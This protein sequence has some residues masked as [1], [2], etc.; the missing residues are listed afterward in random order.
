MALTGT[1]AQRMAARDEIREI[2]ASLEQ[3]LERARKQDSMP[4]RLQAL[5]SAL[6]VLLHTLS[7]EPKP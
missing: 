1:V 7:E 4:L 2:A 6:A 5:E 3:D